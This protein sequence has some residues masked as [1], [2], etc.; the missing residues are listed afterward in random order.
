M[1]KCLICIY[2]S[3]YGWTIL[4]NEELQTFLLLYGS[5]DNDPQDRAE[6]LQA[7]HQFVQTSSMNFLLSLCHVCP[8]QNGRQGG[9]LI[10]NDWSNYNFSSLIFGF[11]GNSLFKRGSFV[12]YQARF[13][14]SVTR[15][16]FPGKEGFPDATASVKPWPGCFLFILIVSFLFRLSNFITNLW[17]WHNDWA[18]EGPDLTRNNLPQ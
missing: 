1:K 7:Q 14:Q 10:L 5:I 2:N 3:Q 12:V 4:S 6:W 16:R 17:N 18:V 15:T 8:V 13:S 9:L 11:D